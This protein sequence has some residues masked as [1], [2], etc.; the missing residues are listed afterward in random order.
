MR[1]SKW[2]REGK[3]TFSVWNEEWYSMVAI[4]CE[5]IVVQYGRSKQTN[6]IKINRL[7][8]NQEF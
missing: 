6:I 4:S 8:L 7:K 2:V 5:I 1:R 3:C